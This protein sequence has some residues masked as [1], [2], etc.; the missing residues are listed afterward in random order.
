[1]YITYDNE[2]KKVIYIGEKKPIAV[3]GNAVIGEVETVPANYDYLTVETEEIR[4]RTVYGTKVETVEK[5]NDEGEKITENVEVETSHDEEYIFCTVKA[6]FF[7]RL[8]EEKLAANREIVQL[9]AKLSET[10]YQAIKYAEG[11]IS[12]ADYAPIKAQRQAWRDRI[13]ELEALL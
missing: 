2:T 1:M 7:E 10:D 5:T 13:N 8:S 6:Y 9:K 4:A 11:F 3:S 12:E